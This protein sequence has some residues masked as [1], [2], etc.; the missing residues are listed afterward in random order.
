MSS[1]FST[2][3]R[4]FVSTASKEI[5]SL[6]STQSRCLI[7][8]FRE[9]GNGVLWRSRTDGTEPLQLTSAPLFALRPRWS[10]D[11]RHLLFIGHSPGTVSTVYV[12]SLNGGAPLP[13]LQEG[14]AHSAYADWSPNGE[15]VALDAWPGSQSEVGIFVVQLHTRSRFHIPASTDKFYVRWSPNGR[16]LAA[17]SEDEKALFLFDFRSQQWKTGR[18]LKAGARRTRASGFF[19]SWVTHHEDFVIMPLQ[20]ASLRTDR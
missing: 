17:R 2:A 15:S 6:I 5:F 13:V 11:G 7:W 16:Y 10:P 3:L 20:A 8:H 4:R 14:T 18:T 19:P 9:T 12:V 1:A